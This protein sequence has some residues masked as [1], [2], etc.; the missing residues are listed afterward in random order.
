MAEEL[1]DVKGAV[2]MVH[3]HGERFCGWYFSKVPLR[4]ENIPLNYKDTDLEYLFTICD[5]NFRFVMPSKIEF[6]E[7]LITYSK[8]ERDLGVF[9]FPRNEK[10]NFIAPLSLDRADDFINLSKEELDEILSSKGPL[11]FEAFKI[12]QYGFEIFDLSEFNIKEISELT[13]ADFIVSIKQEHD[14]IITEKTEDVKS[15]ILSGCNYLLILQNVL[16]RQWKN[17]DELALAT[18]GILHI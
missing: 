18:D 8:G 3:E 16:D 4:K 7:G 2:H 17:L 14:R 15:K 12:P 9:R 1:K 10:G 11:V 13:D 6:I 5:H